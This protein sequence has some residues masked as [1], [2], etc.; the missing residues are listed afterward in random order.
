MVIVTKVSFATTP[1]HI[2]VGVKSKPKLQGNK[3]YQCA[4]KDAQRCGQ[5]FC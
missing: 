5:D 4:Y 2:V 1:A 3:T